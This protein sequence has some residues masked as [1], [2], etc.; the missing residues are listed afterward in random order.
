MNRTATT[1]SAFTL[2]E[3]LVVVAIIGVLVGLLLPAVQAAR[4]SSR[5]GQCTNN[6]KQI[7]LGILNYESVRGTL[8]LAYTPNDSGGQLFGPCNGEKPPSTS[9]SNP[10]NGLGKH[11]ILSFVLPFM[12]RDTMHNQMNFKLDYDAGQN[13]PVT[14][15]DVRDFI[16]PS[17]DSRKGVFATDYTA[18][19]DIHDGNYCKYVEAAGLTKWQ[20][21]V[22]TLAGMLADVPT[23]TRKV[24]DGLSKTFMFF[25]SAG[26]PNRYINGVLQANHPVPRQEYE[27]AS[28][29]AYDVFGNENQDQCPITT[30]MNCDNY[31]EIYSFHPNGAVFAFGDGSV[32][33]LN[34]SIDLD[35]FICMFTR[36]ANDVSG[37]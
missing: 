15:Q 31:H 3:L 29:L 37:L 34:E 24:S 2:V 32:E 13:E 6:M 9:K 14:R 36:A 11:F 1:R 33:Y 28:N 20:R 18:F 19:V 16:C 21:P 8:P 35:V 30:I 7:G 23:R 17:G 25:E 27:W 12:E 10:S 22:E 4:E 26:K 5:R